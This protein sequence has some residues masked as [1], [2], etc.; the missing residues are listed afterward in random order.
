MIPA[1]ILTMPQCGLYCAPHI[2]PSRAD[3]RSKSSPSDLAHKIPGWERYSNYLCLPIIISERRSG[4]DRR[5]T[6]SVGSGLSVGP[7]GSSVCLCPGIS[8]SG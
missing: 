5:G 3:V 7:V 1:D 2:G 8:V 6:G 4:A